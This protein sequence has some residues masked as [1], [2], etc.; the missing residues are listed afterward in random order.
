MKKVLIFIIGA[1]VV[2]IALGAV[3]MQSFQKAKAANAKSKDEATVTRDDLS[4]KV[5]ESGSIDAVKAVEVKSRVSGRVAKLFVDEG[6]R[7]QAGQLIAIIDPQETELRVEQDRAQ[8]RGAQS[9]VERQKIEI[10]QRRITAAAA[11]R[12]SLARVS[13]LEAEVK[14]QP[15]LTNSA[16]EQARANLANAEHEKVRLTQSAHPNTRVS[17]ETAVREA[18]ANYD[19][20]KREVDRQRDLLAKG[21]A[22]QRSVESAQ[23]Q[24]DLA[25]ARLDSAQESQRRLDAQINSELQKAEQSIL[26]AKAELNRA[27]AGAVTDQTKGKDLE[28]AR[29]EALKA[30]AALRDVEVMKQSL[31]QSEASV[32]QISSVLS[33]SERQLRETEIRAPLSGIVTRKLIQEGELVANLSS[34]SSGT[35]IVRIEDQATMRVM[36][37]VNEIDVAKLRLGLPAEIEVDA[38]PKEKFEGTVRKIAPASTAATAAD[39]VVRYQ[40]EIY[41]DSPDNRLKSGMSAKCTLVT[42]AKE[43]VLSLP[44]EYVG[45]DGE[46]RFVEFPLPKDSKPG[47][48][49]ERKDIK[50]GIQTGSKIEILDGVKEGDKVIKPTFN[51]PA[52][53]GA[54]SFGNG[55]EDE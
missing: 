17:A 3:A 49:P 37:N 44:L 36:L 4:V 47:T 10:E 43:K 33:D 22:A 48:K 26:Q 32:Q 9:A 52:R 25:R 8:L 24:L 38:V 6:D 15:I 41:V 19:N 20:A 54:M 35:P 39:A 7:V 2:L 21:Y 11:Y 28:S 29:A 53:Q 13:Q 5:I 55:D 40:V 46:K 30:K 45:R 51:G 1:V 14:A 31:H 18:Q 16:I 23:L 12:Q 42:T 34:F 27:K 50:V